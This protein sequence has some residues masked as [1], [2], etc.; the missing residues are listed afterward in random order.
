MWAWLKIHFVHGSFVCAKKT[1]FINENWKTKKRKKLMLRWIFQSRNW[2]FFIFKFITY[3]FDMSVNPK[4]GDNYV[5][6]QIGERRDIGMVKWND[7]LEN[8]NQKN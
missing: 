4:S 8:E 3:L 2:I 1:I 7:F 6:N 5:V